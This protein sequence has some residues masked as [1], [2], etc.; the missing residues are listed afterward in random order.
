MLIAKLELNLATS[1][2]QDVSVPKGLVVQILG[3]KGVSIFSNPKDLHPAFRL[4]VSY[5]EQH[6]QERYIS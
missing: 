3:L 1:C 6:G 2:E 5:G 4:S